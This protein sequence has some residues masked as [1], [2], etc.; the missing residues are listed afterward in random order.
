MQKMT[1]LHDFDVDWSG[2]VIHGVDPINDPKEIIVR[3]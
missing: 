3:S 2:R 1:E